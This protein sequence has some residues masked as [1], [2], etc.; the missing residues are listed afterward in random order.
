MKRNIGDRLEHG[1][2]SYRKIDPEAPESCQGCAM[3]R[4]LPEC[5]AL[6]PHEHDFQQFETV[7]NGGTD[8]H[9]GIWC[10]VESYEIN[11]RTKG[12]K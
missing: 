5:C 3:L 12:T 8:C 9:D 7:E 4:P 2:N 1:G 11:H 10:R 6:D